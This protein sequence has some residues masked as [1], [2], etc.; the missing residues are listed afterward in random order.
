MTPGIV[1]FVTRAEAGLVPPRSISRNITPEHGG[2]AAHWGGSGSPAATH[3]GC[4]A[5]WRRWQEFHMSAGWAGTTNGGTDIA[6]NGGYCNHGYAFAGRGI[7]IRSGAQGT[8]VGSQNYYAFV[9]LGGSGGRPNGLA[10]AA[11]LWWIV[12]ARESGAGLE[13]QPHSFFKNTSCP[14]SELRAFISDHHNT[15]LPQ[16]EEDMT[17]EQDRLLREIHSIMA[18][19]VKE[20]G[21]RPSVPVLRHTESNL[22]HYLRRVLPSHTAGL[23][24][25]IIPD[26]D[27]ATLTDAQ[28]ED[29]AAAIADGIDERVAIAAYRVLG[30]RLNT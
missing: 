21:G 3:A 16:E 29:V 17:P 4:L 28:V 27:T 23:V 6:Y 5:M 26:V 19:E 15:P 20:V 22:S 12:Q 25:K 7:G 18:I 10:L 8:T 9:W 30:E 11:L 14:G 13:V 2:V 1:G 24:E